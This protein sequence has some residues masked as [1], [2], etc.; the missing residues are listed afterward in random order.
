VLAVRE[1]RSLGPASV[2][3]GLDLDASARS[4]AAQPVLFTSGQDDGSRVVVLPFA[5]ATRAPAVVIKT[6]RLPGFTGHTA[7]EQA[8]LTQLRRQLDPDLRLTLPEPMGIS[9]SDSRPAFIET[10]VPGRM[11]AASSGGWRA[12]PARQLDDLHVAA[13]WLIRFHQAT[14]ARR[15]EWNDAETQ[16]WIAPRL[17][18]YE[19]AFGLNADEKQLFAAVLDRARGLAGEQLPIV[20]AHND[21][22][23]WHIYRDRTQVSVIDW[24]FGSDRLAD[25]EGLPLCDLAYFTA[26]WIHLSRG[27]HGET[28]QLQGF[29]DLCS[30]QSRT[31]V[32]TNAARRALD[33][34]LARLGVNHAFLPLLFAYTWLERAVD[35][36]R[37]QVMLGAPMASP[38]QDNR[39]VRYVETVAKARH[40]L[41]ADASTAASSVVS[42]HDDQRGRQNTA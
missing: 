2:F 38:R 23:P 35:R 6:A 16:L 25:R 34:Y 39:F 37:R 40:D 18:S 1:G 31:D 5:A 13:D 21:F 15:V 19:H 11:V 14:V 33:D 27:L 29:S 20:C 8:T 42:P 9:G 17:N 12:S 7:Q 32:R 22:N 26:H 10:L 24:E 36:H 3:A 4:A 41:F 28:A 30:N